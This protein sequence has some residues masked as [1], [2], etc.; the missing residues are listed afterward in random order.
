MIKVIN[1]ILFLPSIVFSQ[2]VNLKFTQVIDTLPFSHEIFFDSLYNKYNWESFFE[3]EITDKKIDIAN[4]DYKLLNAAIFYATNEQRVKHHKKELKFHKG[5]EN[6]AAL[7]SSQ[8]ITYNFFSHINTKQKQYKTLGDRFSFCGIKYKSE[9]YGYY[10]GRIGE[11]IAISFL[12]NYKSNKPYGYE[13]TKDGYIF[14]YITKK[15]ENKEII[16]VHT[17]KSFSKYLL[18]ECWMKSHKHKKNILKN[19]YHYLGCGAVI[20]YRTLNKNKIPKIKAT[21]CFAEGIAP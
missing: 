8:M 5:L 14:Y 3:L 7:H 13:K 16:T 17:Y 20:D 4:P 6:A 2:N 11:N 21:Q 9:K 10:Y 1:I 15:G 18:Q 12:I 19:K